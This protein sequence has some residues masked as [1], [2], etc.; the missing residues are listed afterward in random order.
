[1]MTTA[2]TRASSSLTACQT[3]ASSSSASRRSPRAREGRPARSRRSIEARGLAVEEDAA[4]V[5]FYELLGVADDADVKTIKKAYYGFA[6]ECHPDVSED[7]DEGHEM[8]VLLNEAYEILSDPTTR[9]LYDSELEQQ[10]RDEEDAFTGTAYSKWTTRHAEQGETRAV[11][12]DEFTCI[13]CKQCVWAA[14]ATFRM[15]DDYGRSRVFAQWLNKEEDLNVAIESCPVDC[16]HWVE[17]D[18]LPYLEHVTVNYEKVSVGIM[19]S[20]TSSSVNAFEAAE[21]FQKA[22]QRR[23]DQRAEEL[24][25]QRRRMSEEEKKMNTSESQRR[26]YRKSADAIRARWSAATGVARSMTIEAIRARNTTNLMDRTEE[27]LLITLCMRGRL[28]ITG[29]YPSRN[30]PGFFFYYAKFADP[31]TWRHHYDTRYSVLPDSPYESEFPQLYN[32]LV[33]LDTFVAH[34]GQEYPLLSIDVQ[35]YATDII[36]VRLNG[37]QNSDRMGLFYTINTKFVKRLTLPLLGIMQ[38]ITATVTTP[39]FKAKLQ[40]SVDQQRENRR[41]RD[42]QARKEQRDR[43]DREAEEARKRQ[44]LADE[45]R[46]R[47]RAAEEAA[48]REAQAAAQRAAEAERRA[49]EAQ[50]QAA[51][52]EWEA[53]MAAAIEQGRDLSPE[54]LKW[55]EENRGDVDDADGAAGGDARARAASL[56]VAHAERFYEQQYNPSKKRRL[57]PIE[58]KRA[59]LKTSRLVRLLMYL[60]CAV[61]HC[62]H[63]VILLFH[64][65]GLKAHE[66]CAQQTGTSTR[67]V[68]LPGGIPAIVRATTQPAIKAATEEAAVVFT[69]RI[70]CTPPAGFTATKTELEFYRDA[71]RKGLTA[72]KYATNSHVSSE[73]SIRA[74]LNG[75]W[76]NYWEPK[77]NAME[78]GTAVADDDLDERVAGRAVLRREFENKS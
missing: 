10:R 3:R 29:P 4:L 64:A 71:A 32:D 73:N 63:D 40:T 46:E 58:A 18:D 48:R 69:I 51:R 76:T 34:E 35:D 15:N 19:Q 14:P 11:F 16:I 33:S 9:A 37:K 31:H 53:R 72:A 12:V 52:E 36:T 60:E 2:P 23:I 55:F 70:P 22:R 20:Q 42:Q 26:A 68:S 49:R 21:S 75:L 54:D 50:R 17:R 74:M 28:R 6:K 39:E 25:E 66:A 65:K 62:M 1:M 5:D 47:A 43:E 27:K 41:M 61:E 78:A 57:M 38:R 7:E 44:R 30:P 67:T 24:A 13:G 45:E 59:D 56:L 8:C 77:I